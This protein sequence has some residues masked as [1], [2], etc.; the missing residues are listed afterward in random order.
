MWWEKISR[1]RL[2]KVWNIRYEF[3]LQIMKTV[4][5]KIVQKTRELPNEERLAVKY[6]RK[7]LIPFRNIVWQL[8]CYLSNAL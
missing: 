3:L 6:L 7:S 4:L 2:S 5:K 8:N 1:Y